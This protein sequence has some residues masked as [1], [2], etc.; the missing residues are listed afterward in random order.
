MATPARLDDVVPSA[1]LRVFQPLDAFER[2]EQLH[3]ERYLLDRSR[4][5]VAPSP[6]RRSPH[7]GP[8]RGAGAG[9][10]R[11][12]RGPR[13]RRAHLRQ[14][15]ADADAGARVDARRSARRSRSSCGISSCRRPT[16]SVPRRTS[17]GS[18]G[19]T[20]TRWRSATRARGTCRSAGSCSSATRNAWL[21]EDEYGRTRLRYRTTHASR[22]APCR[23]GRPA[24]SALRPRADQRPDRGPPP[25]D[26]GVRPGRRSSSSTTATLCDFM[27][28][29][30]LDDDHSAREIHEALE[31]LEREEFPRS[32][33]HLPGRAHALGRGPQPRGDELARNA[34]EPSARDG[35]VGRRRSRG[36]GQN[37]TADTAVFSRVLCQLSYLAW[38]WLW[39]AGTA[40]EVIT[41]A[42]KC[43]E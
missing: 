32:G 8:A 1:Y 2:D 30:E 20:R 19:A 37:R 24:A 5:R 29:D 9:R 3:W 41:S 17:R 33:R 16:G 22:D 31:A 18:A 38:P 23:A 40:A 39:P 11:A 4:S 42:L 25:V 12:R 15:V 35:S 36:Q 26:G 34:T 21:G 13:D 6:I 43:S 27:R 7:R 28:W 10:R 14:P